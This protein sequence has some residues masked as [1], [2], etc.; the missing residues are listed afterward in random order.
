MTIC[1]WYVM[2][3]KRG[4]GEGVQVW[5]IRI[6]FKDVSC[7]Y[8]IVLFPPPE[9]V[10]RAQRISDINT[11]Y[12]LNLNSWGSMTSTEG[13]TRGKKNKSRS[14]NGSSVVWGIEKSLPG[15]V[16]HVSS[17][18]AWKS[19]TRL[20]RLSAASVDISRLLEGAAV[21]K[22]LIKHDREAATPSAWD[23][24]HVGT[25]HELLLKHF[26]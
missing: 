9:E 18:S 12:L 22:R 6:K 21:R 23:L 1:F 4:K 19:L 16:L 7:C 3:E 10:L 25:L 5:N 17:R 15:W 8:L 26:W 2:K 11:L 13:R 20:C 24:L 14:Q